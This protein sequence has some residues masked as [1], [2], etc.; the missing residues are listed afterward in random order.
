MKKTFVSA[1]GFI[2]LM[3]QLLRQLLQVSAIPDFKVSSEFPQGGLPNEEY[4]CHSNQ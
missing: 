4:L 3:D 2:V 1:F